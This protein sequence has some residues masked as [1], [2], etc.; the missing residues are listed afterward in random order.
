MP[1][2]CKKKF[3]SSANM[4][5]WV[6][7]L[8]LS[9][10]SSQLISPLQN[11]EGPKT[12]NSQQRNVEPGHQTLQTD[13]QL[14]AVDH[15]DHSDVDRLAPSLQI[16]LSVHPFNK[17]NELPF[18]LS[19]IELQNYPKSRINVLVQTEVYRSVLSGQYDR[20]IEHLKYNDLTIRM[21]KIWRSSVE[22]E[23]HRFE[24]KIGE[25]D[26]DDENVYSTDYWSSSRYE[27]LMNLKSDGFSYALDQ[28]ADYCLLQDADV[29]LTNPDT[30]RSALAD[31]EA[32]I[33]SPMLFSF[34]L[35]SNFWAGMDANGY[36]KRTDDYVPIL[37]RQQVGRFEV[38]MVYSLVFI[39]LRNEKARK[40]KFRF[41]DLEEA[42]LIKPNETPFDDIIVFAKSARSLGLPMYVDNHQ[43]YGFLMPPIDKLSLE[44]QKR[45]LVDLEL[46]C[47]AELGRRFEVTNGLEQFH[48]ATTPNDLRV[49][50]VYVINLERRTERRE[51]MRSVCDLLGLDC[52]F[53][54]A[55]D[56][57]LIDKH[58]LITNRINVMKGYLDPF[59]KRPMT[60]GEIGCFMSHYNIWLDVVKAG[61]RW[62]LVFED[63][64]RFER[65][66]LEKFD[67]LMD[68]VLELDGVDFVY[69]GRKREGESAE[70][71][72]FN[73][74]TDS[75]LVHPT[76][77]YWTIGYLISLSGAKKL[78]N[79]EPLSK[80]I[81][82][83]EFLPIMYDR[84][85]NAE[86]TKHFERRDL[87]ALSVHPLLV[88][89]LHYV[90]EE[91]YVSDTEQSAKLDHQE[92]TEL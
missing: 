74:R 60:Y 57:K 50:R 69:L 86:W 31:P 85:P 25:L 76:Y 64:V 18:V 5:L 15:R 70:E 37:E 38:P 73:N 49:D 32:P 78:V 63:D 81:P 36:Y 61:R 65:D 23:Y 55:V 68:R 72:W 91:L 1:T 44:R 28:W 3:S 84:H 33:L 77:S 41:K 19:G 12:A 87:I 2:K 80:L 66:F 35:Y 48:Q 21:L 46:E 4:I 71:S 79:S 47:L 51:Y 16:V 92:H 17:F 82:V 43:V 45:N 39:N 53:I 7:L 20:A 42:G 34:K 9:V 89:P 88:Q 13:H 11:D 59:H 6:L 62:S 54:S 10:V 52:H 14:N 26:D 24:L 40:L 90:G 27:R 29:I 8:G 30:Y 58:Y 56:G 67:E 83:D 75:M 22:S